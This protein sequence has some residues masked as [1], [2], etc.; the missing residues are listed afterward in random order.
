M[1]SADRIRLARRSKGLSQEKLAETVGV[2]RSAVAHWESRA[3][4]RPRTEH[5]IAVA[6][7]VG[8]S[9]DW[10]ATGRG[11][12]EIPRDVQLD[13]IAAADA[14]LVEDEREVRLVRL[15]R[16]MP[17]RA[18]TALL[19]MSELLATRPARTPMR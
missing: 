2:R 7:V 1:E 6:Q 14:I 19:D 15:F 8:V 5:L 13:S 9:V 16:T 10:L 11:Q 17:L 3:G 4:T 12:P 18:R